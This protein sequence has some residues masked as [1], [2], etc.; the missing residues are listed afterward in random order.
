MI[1]IDWGTSQLRAYRLDGAGAVLDARERPEGVL[2]VSPGGFPAA[3]DAIVAGWDADRVL[4]SG[5]VGSRQ[6]WLEVPYVACPA[7]LDAIARGVRSVAWHGGTAAICPG[8]T[9]YD[10]D[11]VPDVMRGEEVQVFGALA[12]D[13]GAVGSILI[14][15]THSKHIRVEQGAIAG[16]TTHMTGE[17]FAV[18]KAHSILGRTMEDGTAPRDIIAEAAAFESGV[19]RARNAGGLLHHLFGARARVLMGEIAGRDA[20]S[21]LSG[22]LIGHTILAAA[23]QAPLLVIGAPILAEHYAAAAAMLGIEAHPLAADR[24]TVAGLIA[25][26]RLLQNRG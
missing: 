14:A 17:V 7:G 22:M 16:F 20:R 21:Y 12:L 25:I 2:S 24:A 18:L 5:M 9:C 8:V 26:D 10:A 15:G 4:M 1:A 3:L 23:P 6:G 19:E 13:A 11:R